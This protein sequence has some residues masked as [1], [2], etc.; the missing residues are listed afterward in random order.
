[1]PPKKAGEEDDDGDSAELEKGQSMEIDRSKSKGTYKYEEEMESLFTGIARKFKKGNGELIEGVEVV[2]QKDPKA[3][4][5]LL[6][7]RLTATK[8]NIFT[9]VV[10]PSISEIRTLNNKDENVEVSAFVVSKG[11]APE[12]FKIKL[13]V[14]HP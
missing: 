2:L 3:E 14:A 13:Q 5:T 11:A 9:G 1:M 6:I 7:V 4:V 8:N 12:R 10:M